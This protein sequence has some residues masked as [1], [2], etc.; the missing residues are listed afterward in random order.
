MKRW[1]LILVFFIP[2][3]ASG[4]GLFIAPRNEIREVELPPTVDGWIDDVATPARDFAGP[5]LQMVT[6][7]PSKYILLAFDLSDIPVGAQIV[8][9]QLSLYC[10]AAPAAI[11]ENAVLRFKESWQ[12]DTVTFPLA[13]DSESQFDMDSGN[14]DRRLEVEVRKIVQTWVNGVPNYGIGLATQGPSTIQ[15]QSLEAADQTPFLRIRYYF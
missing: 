8:S 6:F 4:C 10:I 2:I 1:K 12:P 14:Q 9:A 13:T 5:A 15:F 11:Q 3:L 7:A